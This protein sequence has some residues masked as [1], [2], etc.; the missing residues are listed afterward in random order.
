M[1]SR[2]R[3]IAL[4]IALAAMTALGLL[5]GLALFD[6]VQEW[7]VAML[8]ADRLRAHAARLEGHRLAARPAALASLCVRPPL[9]E[10]VAT[11]QALDGGRYVV[12]WRH[13]GSGLVLAEVEGRGRTGGRERD[14]L[15]LRPD[16]GRL[17]GG[18]YGCPEATRLLP[19]GPAWRE[20]HPEG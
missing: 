13:L 11:G 1:V 7:R 9:A 4:P 20:G 10:V 12:T 15:L 16:S 5:S 8:A 2:R 6:A 17:V 3:G 14:R 19:S 18:L